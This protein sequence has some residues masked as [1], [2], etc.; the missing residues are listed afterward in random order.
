MPE[1]LTA[2]LKWGGSAVTIVS[3]IA[4]VYVEVVTLRAHAYDALCGAYHGGFGRR[5]NWL[6]VGLIAITAWTASWRTPSVKPWP[7]P[8]R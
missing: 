1:W 3:V 6:V 4:A 5:H 7:M 2:L 8:G